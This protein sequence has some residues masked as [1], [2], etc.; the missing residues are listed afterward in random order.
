MGAKLLII[1]CS[2]K[3]NTTP[4]VLPAVDRYRPGAY[5]Q[6][7]HGVPRDQWPEIIVL[8][9][10][11]GFIQGN[12]PIPD[13]DQK[14]T[15]KV[16]SELQQDRFSLLKLKRMIPS[17]CDDVLICAGKLYRRVVM[18]HLAQ[19][20]RP[21]TQITSVYGGIGSQRSQLKAW[22]NNRPLFE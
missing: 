3:K 22:L 17:D 10:R 13:Y 18:P 12:H 15:S 1:S 11:Y 7:L 14:M 2:S 5:Y 9:A 19:L 21:E 20:F 6:I 8:S 4:G 16:A